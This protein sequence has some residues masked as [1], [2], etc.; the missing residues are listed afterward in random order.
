L[1]SEV[2]CGANPG[3]NANVVA[4]V[5]PQSNG[6]VGTGTG[7]GIGIDAG[8]G[9]NRVLTT[10]SVNVVAS[11]PCNGENAGDDLQDDNLNCDSN[12]WAMNIFTSVSP[13]L[14]IH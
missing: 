5:V 11:T 1:P 12:L 8:N 2:T 13:T 14:C 7:V 4:L 6:N 10:D 9:N 3:G